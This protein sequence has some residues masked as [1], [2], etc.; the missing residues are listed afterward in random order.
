M[1]NNI[2]EFRNFSMP[3]DGVVFPFKKEYEVHKEFCD[4]YI[5]E[6][7]ERIAA[8]IAQKYDLEYKQGD[9]LL[10]KDTNQL[11]DIELAHDELSKYMPV[12]KIR[13]S[14]IPRMLYFFVYDPT[15]SKIL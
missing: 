5:E 15:E 8:F 13:T 7:N 3:W 14:D 10:T 9:A 1:D 12:C 6:T 11:K 2:N 4:S